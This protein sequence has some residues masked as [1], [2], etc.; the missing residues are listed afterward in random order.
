MGLAR[1]LVQLCGVDD[2]AKLDAGES[3]W[4][5]ETIQ[6]LWNSGARVV[7]ALVHAAARGPGAGAR[8]PGVGP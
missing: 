3:P 1:A 8:G 2:L 6:E 5:L 4:A 7:E